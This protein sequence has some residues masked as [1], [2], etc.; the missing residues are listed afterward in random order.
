MTCVEEL[1]P[2]SYDHQQEHD[3]LA[4]V[5]LNLWEGHVSQLHDALILSNEAGPLNF[6][7]RLGHLSQTTCHPPPN[8]D[9]EKAHTH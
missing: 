9:F 8:H 3:P 5:H 6:S 7:L 2:L 1:V 4:P